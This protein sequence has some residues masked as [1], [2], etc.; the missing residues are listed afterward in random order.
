MEASTSESQE[1]QLPIYLAI[2]P[3]ETAGWCYFNA[4]G[5]PIAYGQ[6]RYENAVK[7][8]DAL[9]VPSLKVCIVE[10][11]V[12]FAHRAQKGAF[13]WKDNKTSQQIGQID[14]MCQMRDVEL[15]KQPSANKNMGFMYMAMEEPSNHSISHQFS[16]M[17][18][19]VYYLQETA[20]VNPP[21]K[22]LP[23]D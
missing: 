5:D 4:T 6:F 1:S 12:N 14:M 7:E 18:H 17:A 11:F 2:D 3:G 10:N 22:F 21:G 9:F 13:N 15:V 20:K 19:G 8:L 23:E 16:A